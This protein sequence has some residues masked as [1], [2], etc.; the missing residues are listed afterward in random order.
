MAIVFF[1]I[2]ETSKGGNSNSE[3]WILFL[4]CLV[5]IIVNG[6]ALSAILFRIF[7]WGITPNRAA[8]LGGNVLIL[9]NLV[10][11]TLQL[12]KVLSRKADISGVGKVIASYLPVYCIW[13]TIVTFVFPLIFGFR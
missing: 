12:Y 5:T 3:K 1:S 8:V 13:T 2:A 7:E 6:I 10:L 9:V 4:L 11:V